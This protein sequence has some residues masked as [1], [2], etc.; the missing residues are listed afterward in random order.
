M[1][2]QKGEQTDVHQALLQT[3][4][5]KDEQ[6]FALADAAEGQTDK[7]TDIHVDARAGRQQKDIHQA[8]VPTG[9]QKDVQTGGQADTLEQSS[10]HIGTYS[11]KAKLDNGHTR[12]DSDTFVNY[13]NSIICILED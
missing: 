6:A 11:S 4:R 12:L 13:I 7:Q 9:R 10:F 3:D 8:H 1:T 5:Q 2:G